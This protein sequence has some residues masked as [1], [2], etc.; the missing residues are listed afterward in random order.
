MEKNKILILDGDHKNCLAIVRHLGQAHL[1]E[2]HVVAY[3]RKSISFLSKY[4][5]RKFVIT[6]PKKDPDLYLK[7]LLQILANDKYLVLIPVSFIS[8]PDMFGA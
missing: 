8:F 7:E 6:S 1:Y 5:D 4:T 3:A 2:I